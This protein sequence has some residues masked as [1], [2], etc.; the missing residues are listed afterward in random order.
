MPKQYGGVSQTHH[1]NAAHVETMDA[2][3]VADALDTSSDEET[4]ETAQELAHVLQSHKAT[5]DVA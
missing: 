4:V 2:V 1:E 5:C 3:E